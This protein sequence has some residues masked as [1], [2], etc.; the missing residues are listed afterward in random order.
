MGGHTF[1]WAHKSMIDWDDN[2]D[3]LRDLSASFYD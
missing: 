1:L 3:V 2:D